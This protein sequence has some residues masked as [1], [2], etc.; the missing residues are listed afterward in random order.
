MYICI[1][2][3]IH[4]EPC[5]DGK[6]KHIAPLKLVPDLP[7]QGLPKKLC[8]MCAR[9]ERTAGFAQKALLHSDLNRQLQWGGPSVLPCSQCPGNAGK[10]SSHP[11][12]SAQSPW[13]SS[14]LL[15]FA[16][17]GSASARTSHGRIGMQSTEALYISIPPSCGRQAASPPS[18]H[19]AAS[20]PP[21]RSKWHRDH[22]LWGGMNRE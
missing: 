10:P 13:I 6:K 15:C 7:L 21:C 17:R 20:R 5:L 3:K 12:C 11:S 1:I 2:S 9:T 8:F 14:K 16:G 18:F 19:T 22:P 4:R